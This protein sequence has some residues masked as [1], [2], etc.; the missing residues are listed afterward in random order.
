MRISR[1]YLLEGKFLVERGDVDDGGFAD[2][3]IGDWRK[4]RR[5]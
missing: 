2:E 1:G 3:C 4:S 5:N